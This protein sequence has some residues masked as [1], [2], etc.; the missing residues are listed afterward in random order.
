MLSFMKASEVSYEK[1]ADVFDRERALTQAKKAIWLE[2]FDKYLDLRQDSRILDVGCGTGRFSELFQG[3]YHCEV[4]G[5]DPASTMLDKAKSKNKREI[6]WILGLGEDLPFYNN[7]FDLCFVS[8]V[9]QHFRNKRRA[10]AESYRVL[11]KGG[12]IAIRTSSH[13]QLKTILDYRFFPLA[14]HLEKERLPDVPQIKAM[15]LET[16]FERLQ[17]YRVRQPLFESVETYLEKLRNG[18]ASFLSLITE[19]EYQ[20]GLKHASEYLRENNFPDDKY[21]E[22]TFLIGFK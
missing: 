11:R 21:T 6:Q 14:I 20:K 1:L 2:L 18:Y 12:R 10:M 8:Q 17:E 19:D 5:I 15:L 13:K 16:G 4:I 7:S 22:I 3:Q 9:I